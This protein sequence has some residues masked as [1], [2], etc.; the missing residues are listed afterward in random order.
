MH[1]VMQKLV[2]AA[3]EGAK[4]YDL[5]VLGDQEIEAG[6]STVYNK[7][8]KGAAVPK[9]TYTFTNAI[10]RSESKYLYY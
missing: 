1:N 10:M 2:A 7:K 3:T 9:G 4:A 6:A 5:A 8:T